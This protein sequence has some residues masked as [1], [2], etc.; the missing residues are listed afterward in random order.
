MKT[1]SKVSKF[2]TNGKHV[3][4]PKAVSDFFKIGDEVTIIKEEKRKRAKGK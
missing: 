4:I 2:S 1:K 3:E